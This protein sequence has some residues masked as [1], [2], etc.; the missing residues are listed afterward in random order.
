M[1]LVITLKRTTCPAIFSVTID[2]PDLEY[3]EEVLVAWNEDYL[4]PLRME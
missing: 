2:L 1:R 3:V 4:V